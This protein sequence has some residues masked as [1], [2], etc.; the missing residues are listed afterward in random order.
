[1]IPNARSLVPGPQS[2]LVG[3]R[4]PPLDIPA[5]FRYHPANEFPI[6][7]AHKGRT[8]RGRL[9]ISFGAQLLCIEK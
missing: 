8:S 5:T 6:K 4:S 9:N 2:N 1:M 3:T 7:G